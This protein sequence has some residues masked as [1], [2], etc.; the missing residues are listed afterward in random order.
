MWSTAVAIRK[1]R[2]A[3]SKLVRNSAARLI[4]LVPSSVALRLRK[5]FPRWPAPCS[6]PIPARPTWQ[7]KDYTAW[8]IPNDRDTRLIAYEDKLAIKKIAARVGVPAVPVLARLDPKSVDVDRHPD[9]QV[10][11]FVLKMNHGWNDVVFVQRLGKGFLRLS[12]AHLTGDY[13]AAEANTRIRRHFIWWSRHV[14][15]P[16]EWAVSMV[17]PRVLFAEASLPMNDDYKVFLIH[18]RVEVIHPTSGRW[19]SDRTG[20][21]FDREWRCI[22][23]DDFA[24]DRFGSTA[25]ERVTAL[26]P[27]PTR[28]E[29]LISYAERMVPNDMSFLRVDF[30]LLPD[31]N[32]LLGEGT[33]YSG[34]GHEIAKPHLEL[35]LGKIHWRALQAGQA[36][37]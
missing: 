3:R 35:E 10:D 1:I 33:G 17:R 9:L 7:L 19:G 26:F 23:A 6:R 37:A 36:M 29:S 30:F 28:L 25:I 2:S 16:Q 5:V 4:P 27:R 14:H 12:G 21:Y 32:F 20:A 8:R 13:N 34:G 31:G 15:S 11:R 24:E 18:G 22:G